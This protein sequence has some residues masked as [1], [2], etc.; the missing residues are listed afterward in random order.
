IVGVALTVIENE[1]VDIVRGQV[2]A[3]RV[4]S[5]V[6]VVHATDLEHIRHTEVPRTSVAG[7]SFN[8]H[9]RRTAHL[10]LD[11]STLVLAGVHVYDRR[12]RRVGL[13][14]AKVDGGFVVG[15]YSDGWRRT[16]QWCNRTIIVESLQSLC[17]S[18]HTI[19]SDLDWV[20]A[21]NFR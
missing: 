14:N 19:W 9:N 3:S 6:R 12:G 5:T 8:Q 15:V 17:G 4:A 2:G 13:G 1:V 16:V 10:L 18:R 7:T 21:Q 11:F 20:A